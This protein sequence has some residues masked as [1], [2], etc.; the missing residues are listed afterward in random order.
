[1]ADKKPPIFKDTIKL[2]IPTADEV[3]KGALVPF[4]QSEIQKNKRGLKSLLRKAHPILRGIDTISVLKELVQ[5]QSSYVSD[6]LETDKS[7]S[8]LETIIDFVKGKNPP[9]SR[10]D[11]LQGMKKAG[12]M[13][14]TP[15][16]PIS[17]ITEIVEKP[18]KS[19]TFLQ[20]NNVLSNLRSLGE[21]LHNEAHSQL[22][23][24]YTKYSS[25]NW[26]EAMEKLDYSNQLYVLED[27]M[28][29]MHEE[30][31]TPE[32]KEEHK[33]LDI[34]LGMRGADYYEEGY[35]ATVMTLE[36][37]RKLLEE[38]PAYLLPTEEEMLEMEKN[39]KEPEDKTNLWV[40]NKPPYE[41][42]SYPKMPTLSEINEQFKKIE[43][44]HPPVLGA[45]KRKKGKPKKV[46]KGVYKLQSGGVIRNPYSYTSRDI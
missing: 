42:V 29:E 35:G 20:A 41:K 31:D 32:G 5:P 39:W 15:N 14:A 18:S 30:F 9:V 25:G 44:K 13:A 37:K 1:M 8:G 11:V 2:N 10:R 45:K 34:Q 46:K 36:R 28:H 7:R 38:I 3:N 23:D 33:K 24:P 12:Q 43:E 4:D 27:M 19:I 40:S 6:T 17:S 22:D 21:R 16:L 26:E